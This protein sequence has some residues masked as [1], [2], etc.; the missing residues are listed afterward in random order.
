MLEDLGMGSG[1]ALVLEEVLGSVAMG[2]YRTRGIFKPCEVGHAPP[3]P[4]MIS[5]E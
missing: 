1:M 4:I 3:L 2:V 5:S